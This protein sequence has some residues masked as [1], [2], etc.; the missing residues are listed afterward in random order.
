MKEKCV[1]LLSGGMD[2]ATLLYSLLKEYDVYPISIVYGQ[3]HQKETTAA[4]NLCE[5]AG[6]EILH[7]WKYVVLDTLQT[8]LPSA[9]TGASTIPEGHYADE[10]MKATVVPNRNMILLSIAGGYAAG[11]GAKYLA[12]GPHM[13]DH[14]IYPDCRPDFIFSATQT[15]RL[16]TGW[17]NDGVELITPF[18]KMTKADIVTLGIRLGVPYERS[19]S[20]YN[21]KE[22]PC[23]KC[24]TCVERTEA[25]FK[26]D[27]QDPALTPQEW[28]DAVEY[29]QSV[30]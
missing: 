1:V 25:F 12:Y 10:N 3:R 26:N 4:R 15:L 22:R 9:L 14:A 2:S 11:L 19:W 28:K 17:N 16:G 5:A 18:S 20:C 21:G 23:L 8:L 13:G 7:R 30:K 27:M 6:K 29:L 24:G